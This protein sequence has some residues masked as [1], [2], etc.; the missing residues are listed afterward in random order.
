MCQLA[1]VLTTAE[2][3]VLSEKVRQGLRKKM[4]IIL[5]NVERKKSDIILLQDGHFVFFDIIGEKYGTGV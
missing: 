2:L 3:R 4:E 5:H 1:G